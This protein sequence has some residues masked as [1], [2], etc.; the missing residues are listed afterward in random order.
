[1][2]QSPDFG[3]DQSGDSIALYTSHNNYRK[4]V[5]KGFTKGELRNIKTEVRRCLDRGRDI[6]KGKERKNA[7]L[8]YCLQLKLKFEFFLRLHNAIT[9]HAKNLIS[10]VRLSQGGFSLGRLGLTTPDYLGTH[11]RSQ[12]ES[13][14]L[15]LQIYFPTWSICGRQELSIKVTCSIQVS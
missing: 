5:R 6:H 3:P 8:G 2:V 11:Q 14:Q 10:A 12:P 7:S 15:A 1:M 4:S 13:K 9:F